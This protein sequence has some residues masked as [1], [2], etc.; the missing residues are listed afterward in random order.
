VPVLFRS[1]GV[2]ATGAAEISF[3]GNATVL[4]LLTLRFS[5]ATFLDFS[6]RSI[7]PL[8]PC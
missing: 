8:I 3:A 2:S 6:S 7:F 1:D 5:F 4:D